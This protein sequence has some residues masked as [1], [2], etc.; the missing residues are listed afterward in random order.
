[1]SRISVRSIL[2]D[3]M[4]FAARSN[5]YRIMTMDADMNFR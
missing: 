1:V 3:Y 4:L 2:V 5:K